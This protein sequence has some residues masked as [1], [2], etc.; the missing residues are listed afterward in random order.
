MRTGCENI[1][2]Q[3]VLCVFNKHFDICRK[4]THIVGVVPDAELVVLAGDDPVGLVVPEVLPP[5]ADQGQVGGLREAGL[6]VQ[7]L[8]HA[9][10]P[11]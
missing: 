9:C 5:F 1:R 4:T 11:L 10:W 3:L 8:Q 6:F 2:I 7:Q